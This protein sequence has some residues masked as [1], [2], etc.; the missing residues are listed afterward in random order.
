MIEGALFFSP[1]LL[2]DVLR[3][4]WTCVRYLVDSVQQSL[5]DPYFHVPRDHGDLIAEDHDAG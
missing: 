3:N 5:F 1:A 4:G 2:G